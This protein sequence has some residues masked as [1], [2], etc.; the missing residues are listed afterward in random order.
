[1]VDYHFFRISH[2]KQIDDTS[3]RLY[4]EMVEGF[5]KTSDI[6]THGKFAANDQIIVTKNSSPST[7][8]ANDRI[9]LLQKK[10]WIAKG[11]FCEK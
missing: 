2:K 6:V 9:N 8:F 3:R 7:A 5:V 4:N 11:S 10:L 1:M